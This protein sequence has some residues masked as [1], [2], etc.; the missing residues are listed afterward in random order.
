MGHVDVSDAL[1]QLDAD[2]SSQLTLG[3][4]LLDAGEEGGVT[5]HM[6]DDEYFGEVLGGP[7][8]GFAVLKG[9]DDGLFTEYMVLLLNGCQDCIAM[10]GILSGDDHRIEV[11]LDDKQVMPILYCIGSL[12]SM[13]LNDVLSFDIIGFCD[14]NNSHLLGMCFCIGGIYMSSPTSCPKQCYTNRLHWFPPGLCGCTPFG[15]QPDDSMVI[16]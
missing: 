13:L 5:K 8:N 11:L 7:G 10:H 1:I 6:G 14:R 12:Y 4:Q 9:G 2:E 16:C 15:A 3:D